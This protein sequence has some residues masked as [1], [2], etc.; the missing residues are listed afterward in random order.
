MKILI[1]FAGLIFA[2]AYISSYNHKNHRN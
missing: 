2:D 1:I